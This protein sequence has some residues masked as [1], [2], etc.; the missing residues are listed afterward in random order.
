M[1]RKASPAVVQDYALR[2]LP[3][4]SRRK[5]ESIMKIKLQ[6]KSRWTGSVLFEYEKENNTIKDT[7]ASSATAQKFGETFT[8]LY[9]EMFL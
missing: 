7:F 4:L 3:V 6:I 5:G 2:K 9:N 1:Y 8:A